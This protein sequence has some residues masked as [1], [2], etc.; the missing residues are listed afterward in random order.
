VVFLVCSFVFFKWGGW[1]EGSLVGFFLGG[2][3][4]LIQH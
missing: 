3:G 1:M 4:V 2:G